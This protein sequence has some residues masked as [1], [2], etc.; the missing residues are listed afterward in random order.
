MS[1][2]YVSSVDGGS[3]PTSVSWWNGTQSTYDTITNALAALSGVGPHIIYVSHVHSVTAGAAITW[4]VSA[5]GAKIAIISVNRSTGV[6]TAGASEAVGAANSA[7]GAWT[8]ASNIAIIYMY[9]ISVASGSNNNTGCDL[10]VATGALVT[11]TLLSCTINKPSVA[12]GA[13]FTLG[14]VAAANQ[15]QSSVRLRSTTFNFAGNVGSPAACVLGQASFFISNLIITFGGTQPAALFSFTLTPSPSIVIVDSDLS[16]YTNASGAYFDI[17]NLLTPVIMNGVKLHASPAFV[18]GTWPAGNM[19]SI[20][21]I[22]VDSGDT[23]NTFGY[24]NRLG[25]ISVN[26]S[27]YANNGEQFDGQHLSW[28]IVTTADCSEY[29]PFYTPWMQYFI[30]STGTKTLKL[31]LLRDSATDFTTRQVW[32][33]FEYLTS[34][35]FP[36]GTLNSTRGTPFDGTSVDLTNSSETWTETLTNNNQ[37]EVAVTD[38]VAEKGTVRARLGVAVAST[39]LYLDPNVWVS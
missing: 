2:V 13:V 24:R 35:S 9:G 14:R 38:T 31:Q 8:S 18:S 16:S 27:N 12:V 4:D 25:T 29:E 3:S 20:T 15:G 34:S 22:N 21:S 37:M 32:G 17:G 36:L 23:H 28:Q 11:L 5:S 10:N 26:T 33:E 19:G 1:T 7:F 39:T 6:W 30:T